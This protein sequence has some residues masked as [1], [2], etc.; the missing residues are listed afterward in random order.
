MAGRTHRSIVSTKYGDRPLIDVP[1]I[2]IPQYVPKQNIQNPRYQMGNLADD[3]NLPPNAQ[4]TVTP[5]YPQP[6]HA[7]PS[8]GYRPYGNV[9]QNSNVI[10]YQNLPQAPNPYQNG[11]VPGYQQPNQNGS[12]PGYQQP[13]QNVGISDHAGEFHHFYGPHGE[14]ISG[15]LLNMN[16]GSQNQ[17]RYPTNF[18]LKGKLKRGHMTS[19]E[20]VE[21]NISYRDLPD[22]V[23]KDLKRLYGTLE[24]VD[25][26]IIAEKGEYHIYATPKQNGVSLVNPGYQYDTR[27]RGGR[28]GSST[29][30]IYTKKY[31][32]SDDVHYKFDP[33]A[34]TYYVDPRS[35]S[36]ASE[37]RRPR[38]YKVT[39]EPRLPVPK[40]VRRDF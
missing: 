20:V 23:I 16:F 27:S 6:N 31:N 33:N 22:V 32:Q 38:E 2:S 37:G 39:E 25:V 8:Y 29:A 34:R 21:S 3:L 15:P 26:T 13:N 9:I 18:K 11:S 40:P 30:D 7:Q 12:V 1:P 36:V 28:H 10:P 24:K 17:M 5:V 14:R 35:Y 4:Q 19:I